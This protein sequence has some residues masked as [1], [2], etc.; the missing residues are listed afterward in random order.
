MSPN[1]P[2][3]L[4]NHAPLF[5]LAFGFVFVAISLLK[6]NPVLKKTGLVLLVLGGLFSVPAYLSGEDAEHFVEEIPG[7]SEHYL[8]EHE[9]LGETAYYVNLLV[10]MLALAALTL[11]GMLEKYRKL[12]DIAVVVSGFIGIAITG[13]AAKHGGQIRR[14]ELWD[15]QE[16]E[17]YEAE[18]HLEEHDH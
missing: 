15:E 8:E 4:W 7:I 14:P 1:Y 11:G 2:H 12:L 10:G 17:V 9:E 5:S 18:E 16:V 3:L 6:A 13:I